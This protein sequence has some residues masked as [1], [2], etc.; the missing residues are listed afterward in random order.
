L[1]ARIHERPSIKIPFPFYSPNPVDWKSN[2]KSMAVIKNPS[3]VTASA[4]TMIV[5]SF[6]RFFELGDPVKESHDGLVH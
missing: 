5:L 1:P 6:Q 2:R 3:R 4:V